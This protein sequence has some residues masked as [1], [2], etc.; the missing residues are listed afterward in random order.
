MATAIPVTTDTLLNN[1]PKLDVKGMN[2]A[3]FSLRFQTA[4][5]AK[6]LWGHM[7]G[8]ATCLLPVLPDTDEDEDE[9]LSKWMKNESLAKHLLVQRIPDSTALCL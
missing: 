3:I 2:W 1:M 7:N 5:E 6:E 8:E 9:E 4:V